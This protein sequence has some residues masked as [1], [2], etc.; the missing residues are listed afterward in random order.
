MAASPLARRLARE[1]GIDITT[2]SGSGFGG[3]IV[4]ADVKKAPTVSSVPKGSC[5]GRP[6]S[7]GGGARAKAVVYNDFE[8]SDLA[9]SG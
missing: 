7:R 4:A 1:A 8:L 9:R 6:A 5:A 3:R 2:L